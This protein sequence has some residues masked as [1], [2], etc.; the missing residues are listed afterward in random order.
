MLHKKILMILINSLSDIR[1]IQ[2][3]H[4]SKKQKNKLE[5]EIHKILLCKI[6]GLKLLNV[7]YLPKS[8][9]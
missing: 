4:K 6:S 8:K 5:I 7:Y 9:I 1:K 3:N 2:E